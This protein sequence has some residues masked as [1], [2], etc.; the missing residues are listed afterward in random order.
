MQTNAKKTSTR[1]LQ[2][3]AACSRFRTL[4]AHP[5]WQ[6]LSSKPCASA[7]RTCSP[8]AALSSCEEGRGRECA[9]VPWSGPVVSVASRE[10]QEGE[11]PGAAK[12]KTS[13]PGL[14]LEI[15][16][17][18]RKVSHVSS[19]SLCCPPCLGAH[20]SKLLGRLCSHHCL[21]IPA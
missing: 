2:K 21:L 16:V 20:S 8:P 11:V 17:E 15:S 10:G 13:P 5:R 12:T 9:A 18:Q 1:H 7:E 6:R 14:S 19:Q 4:S 3:K